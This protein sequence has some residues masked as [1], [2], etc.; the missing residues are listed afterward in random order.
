MS[1]SPRYRPKR[2]DLCADSKVKKSRQRRRSHRMDH[3]REWEYRHAGKYDGGQVDPRWPSKR[4][5]GYQDAGILDS[6]LHDPARFT[7][8]TRPMRLFE[9]DLHLKIQPPPNRGVLLRL[10]L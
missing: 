1:R 7:A 3:P 5:E 6:H 8:R 4:F 2:R 10:T 9:K